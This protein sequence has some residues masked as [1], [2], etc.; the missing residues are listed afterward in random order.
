[1]WEAQVDC[2]HCASWAS[3]PLHQVLNHQ[4]RPGHNSSSTFPGT[5]ERLS[6]FNAY[7]HFSCA[8][9]QDDKTRLKNHFDGVWKS[10]E[11]KGCLWRQE[12]KTNGPVMPSCWPWREKKRVNRSNSWLWLDEHLRGQLASTRERDL[13]SVLLICS[14]M[15]LGN[16]WKGCDNL[17]WSIWIVHASVSAPSD[18]AVFWIMAET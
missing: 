13:L 11:D 6:P 16:V 4:F 14:G 18:A 5:M 8:K 1:M 7:L 10:T 17:Q 15:E 2:L 12:Q 3:H 9:V